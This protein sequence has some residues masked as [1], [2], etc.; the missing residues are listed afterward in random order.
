MTALRRERAGVFEIGESLQLDRLIAAA[1]KDSWT[2]S[3][4]KPDH[5]LKHLNAIVLGDFQTHA[6][7]HGREVREAETPTQSEEAT[8]RV[9]ASTGRFLGLGRSGDAEGSLLPKIVFSDGHKIPLV[10]KH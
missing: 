6:F 10:I 1:C 5:V 4:L 7:L 2:R 8:L 9:Y 3:L